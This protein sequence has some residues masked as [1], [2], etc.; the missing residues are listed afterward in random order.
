MTE[1][2][3]IVVASLACVG[4]FTV[5]GVLFWAARWL[6]ERA[7]RA[8]ARRLGVDLDRDDQM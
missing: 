2:E 6:A 3:G 1:T 5:T 7:K 4:L 8:L